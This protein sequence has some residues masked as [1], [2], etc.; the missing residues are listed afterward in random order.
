MSSNESEQML[1]LLKELIDAE[2]TRTIPNLNETH[3]KCANRGVKRSEK[4]SGCLRNK[5]KM[6]NCIVR[7]TIPT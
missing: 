7:A 4:K 5:R 1:N 6:H 3:V 2:G